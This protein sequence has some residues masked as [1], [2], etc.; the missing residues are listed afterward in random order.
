MVERVHAVFVHAAVRFD[1]V[2]SFPYGSGT[3]VYLVQ[4]AGIFFAQQQFIGQVSG[5]GPGQGG[6]QPGCTHKAGL[7]THTGVQYFTPQQG[8]HAGL[9]TF[10]YQIQMRYHRAGR[11][12]FHGK[13]SA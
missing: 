11:L 13:T 4:P 7:Q 9:C 8:I 12:R 2:P 3:A 10:R 1:G 5:T 6:K